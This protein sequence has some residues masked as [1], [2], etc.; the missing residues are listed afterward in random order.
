[1]KHQ[2]IRPRGHGGKIIIQNRM[3]HQVIHLRDHGGKTITN[4]KMFNSHQKMKKRK[5]RKQ[6]RNKM[7]KNKK[8]KKTK[9]S[10]RQCNEKKKNKQLD[11]F[12]G[13]KFV[14]LTNKFQGNS[15]ISVAFGRSV[16]KRHRQG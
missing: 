3:K 4:I 9:K 12:I 15:N 6:M 10:G 11:H 2:V 13:K 16:R 5:T 1:M 8:M 7:K 14:L